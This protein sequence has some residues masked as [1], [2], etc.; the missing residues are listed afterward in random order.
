MENQIERRVVR[1]EV[2]G[3]LFEHG[4]R[5]AMGTARAE[6]GGARGHSGRVGCRHED[7]EF[8][9]EASLID[10]QVGVERGEESRQRFDD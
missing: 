3:D 6:G 5:V 9:L 1:G 8:A 10:R 4:R 2:G 7:G